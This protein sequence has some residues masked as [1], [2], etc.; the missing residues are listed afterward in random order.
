MDTI[1]VDQRFALLAKIGENM[2]WDLLTTEQ[3]QVGISE[4]KRAGA[5]AT[6]FVQNGFRVQVGDF[7]R[8]T[9]EVV[10]QIPPLA[11]PTFEELQ[12]KFGIREIECD[13]SPTELVTLKLGTVLR[14]DD[15]QINGTEYERRRSSLVGQ[16]GY[17]QLNWLV[18]HQDEHPAFKALLG[19]IYIDGTGIIVVGARGRRDFPYLDQVGGRWCLHWRW[20]GRGLGRCGRVAVSG[21]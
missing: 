7:F 1:S 10:I 5:E 11:R 21:K 17:Q 20:A 9:G 19:K 4:A 8:E 2:N 16:F 12:S 6:A 14:P 13:I 18:E 15:V 3:V